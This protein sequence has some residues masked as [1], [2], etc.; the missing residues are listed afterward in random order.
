MNHY[1]TDTYGWFRDSNAHKSHIAEEYGWLKPLHPVSDM[2]CSECGRTFRAGV[3][4]CERC[5][6]HASD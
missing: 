1:P 5:V 2:V 6:N 4:Y 3:S